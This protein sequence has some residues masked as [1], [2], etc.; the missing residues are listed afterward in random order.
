MMELKETDQKTK[1]ILG[2]TKSSKQANTSK[3]DQSQEKSTEIIKI[4]KTKLKKIE[5]NNLIPRVQNSV[6]RPVLDLLISK[7]QRQ[8][9]IFLKKRK[10]ATSC[11]D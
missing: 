11:F 3:V 1:A 9:R 10:I 2:L 4:P 5:V 8:V 7:I 6:G